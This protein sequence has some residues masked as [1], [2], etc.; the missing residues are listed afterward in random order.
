MLAN[1]EELPLNYNNHKLENDKYY[2]DC[3]GCHIEP[4]WLLIYKIKDNELILLLM[5]TGSHFDLFR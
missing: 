2:Q 4:D 5:A 3:L 1:K